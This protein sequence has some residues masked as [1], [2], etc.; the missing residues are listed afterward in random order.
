MLGRFL[1]IKNRESELFLPIL[2]LGFINGKIMNPFLFR[3]HFPTNFQLAK[4]SVVNEID[5][6]LVY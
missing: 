1:K 4:E 5:P 3:I 2:N 6:T